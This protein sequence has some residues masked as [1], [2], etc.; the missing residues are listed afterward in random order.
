M[1]WLESIYSIFEDKV[2]AMRLEVDGIMWQQQDGFEYVG[3]RL[4]MVGT[5]VKQFCS[6]FVQEVLPQCS[7]NSAEAFESS[8]GQNTDG[9]NILPKECIEEGQ[10]EKEPCNANLLHQSLPKD[11]EKG[12]CYF[13]VQDIVDLN[14]WIEDPY[15]E[16]LIQLEMSD[17]VTS[18]KK[19]LSSSVLSTTLDDLLASSY[20]EENRLQVEMSNCVTSDKEDTSLSVLSPTSSDP[21]ESSF[22]PKMV[23]SGFPSSDS[24]SSFHSFESDVLDFEDI[25]S[26][27]PVESIGKSDNSID[28]ITYVGSFHKIE[29][30]ESCVIVESSESSYDFHEAATFRSYKEKL[31]ASSGKEGAA[32]QDDDTRPD[33]ESS[34]QEKEGPVS[35]SATASDD[36]LCECDWE[37]V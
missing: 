5:S 4:Q 9:A 32:K 11:P 35:S 30:D 1:S 10:L 3:N 22:C 25:S 28:D 27:A 15:E 36:E 8:L 31:N 33:S 37:I 7:E 13:C 16:R 18:D 19:N 23:P 6:D 21:L 17:S 34:Q 20:Y 14:N 2:E 12:A 24:V 29:L 26:G